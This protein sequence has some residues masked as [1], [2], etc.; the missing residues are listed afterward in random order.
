MR[1][2]TLTI[3]QA[4]D[5]HVE[6]CCNCGVVFAM[7]EQFYSK[8]YENKG[9]SFYCPNGHGQHY[10][11]QT[12]KQLLVEAERR[13]AQTIQA[14]RDQRLAAERELKRIRDRARGGVCPC[15]NR[16]FVQLNRHIKTKH[17][18]FDA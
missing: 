2:S 5:F 16:S 1:G 15:C 8:R 14:E 17:P 12:D 9:T 11:G 3:Q 18:D 6:E 10:V 4:V 7:T 13:A